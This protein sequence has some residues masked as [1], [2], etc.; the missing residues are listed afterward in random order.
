MGL[1]VAGLIIVAALVLRAVFG[2]DN[3]EDDTWEDREP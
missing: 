1:A 2:S 3:L